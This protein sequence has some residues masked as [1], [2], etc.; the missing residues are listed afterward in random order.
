MTQTQIPIPSSDL[1][2][3]LSILELIG[4]SPTSEQQILAIYA[5]SDDKGDQLVI[6]QAIR[7][8]KSKKQIGYKP[9]NPHL[10]YDIQLLHYIATNTSFFQQ[11]PRPTV[12]RGLYDELESNSQ[13]IV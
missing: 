8:L 2:L 3:H 10:R 9:Y 5:G 4:R 7:H 1:V 13:V 12:H 11:D 6:R